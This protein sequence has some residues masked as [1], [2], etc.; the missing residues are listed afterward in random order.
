MISTIVASMR[1]MPRKCLIQTKQIPSAI[2]DAGIAQSGCWLRFLPLDSLELSHQPAISAGGHDYNV[3]EIHGFFGNDFSALENFDIELSV[4]A[5][6]DRV[7]GGRVK[8]RFE[9]VSSISVA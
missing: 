4:V 7:T 2:L 3:F 6:L 8:N 5:K 9:L 1:R